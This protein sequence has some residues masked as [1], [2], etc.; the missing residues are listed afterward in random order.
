MK[1]YKVEWLDVCMAKLEQRRIVKED[2]GEVQF[3][4]VQK[5]LLS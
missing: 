4:T 3:F 5:G 2:E 1:C